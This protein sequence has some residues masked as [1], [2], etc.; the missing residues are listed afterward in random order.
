MASIS[1][2]NFIENIPTDCMITVQS[3]TRYKDKPQMELEKFWDRFAT[4]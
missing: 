1:K 2:H 4:H 3:R